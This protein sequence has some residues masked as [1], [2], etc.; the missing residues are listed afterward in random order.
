LT[1]IFWSS[2]GDADVKKN[3]CDGD[4]LVIFKICNTMFS[5]NKKQKYVGLEKK[6]HTSYKNNHG[7]IYYFNDK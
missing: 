3:L 5:K 7:S 6:L 4:N 1:D 2:S